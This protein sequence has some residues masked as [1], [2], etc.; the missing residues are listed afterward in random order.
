MIN[1]QLAPFCT[2]LDLLRA[3]LVE[4][5]HGSA[6][7]SGVIPDARRAIIKNHFQFIA[8]Q[9]SNLM[10]ERA[11]SRLMRISPMMDRTYGFTELFAEFKALYEA[12]EDDI[13]LERFFHYRK[14]K[15]FLLLIMPGEW[16]ATL[17]AFEPAK[18]DIEEAVD[19]YASEHETACVFHL[20]R[21]L[22]HGLRAMA[23]DV[24]L[25]F[26]KQN[27]HNI[28][29]EIE[30]KIEAERKTLSKGAP[31]DERLDFLSKA[32]K[33]FFYF[34]DGWRNHVSHNRVT[35]DELTAHSTLN[36]VRD[37]MNHLSTK[38]YE[39]P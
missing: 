33:E 22:E 3:I 38:L 26:D 4:G 21:V 8:R 23:R 15:G 30:S 29:D 37:F 9:C 19:C 18:K 14:D 28:I 35:Y 32:A 10:L 1:F 17:K 5:A 13:R 2:A 39:T 27:W 16:A 24:G 11:D 36:H 31:R 20:M 25:I 7:G 6:E 12:I 34:K